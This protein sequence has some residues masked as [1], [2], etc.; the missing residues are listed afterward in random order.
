MGGCHRL[1]FDRVE[2]R[3]FFL[4]LHR[5]LVWVVDAFN[6][7][8]CRNLT[9]DSDLHR[10]G[11]TRT[12]FEFAKLLYS[13]D[14]WTDPHGSLLHLDGLAVKAG[15]HDWILDVWEYFET[16]QDGFAGRL[17]PTILPGW[18][19][20]RALAMKIREDSTRLQ[21]SGITYIFASHL[22]SLYFR[23]T[24]QVPRR[25]WPQSCVFLPF[26]RCSRTRWV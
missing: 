8:P 1:D 25:L 12:A 6:I 15:T 18:W 17:T 26:F 13:L 11:C 2:N 21:A 7:V 22:T 19:Y 9:T 14:P 24:H 4:A 20:T 3:P 5:Q 16:N 23:T 10:R